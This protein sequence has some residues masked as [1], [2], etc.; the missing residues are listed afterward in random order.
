MNKFK[1]ILYSILILFLFFEVLVVFPRHLKN[2]NED[3][4]DNDLYEE[5]LHKSDIAAQKM[6]GVHLVESKGGVKVWELMA[7]KAEG[8]EATGNWDL[9]NVKLVLYNENRVSFIILGLEGTIENKTKNIQIRGG[10]RMQSSNGYRFTTNAVEYISSE[11]ELRSRSNISMIGPVTTSLEDK[12]AKEPVTDMQVTAQSMVVHI[13]ENR[14][15]LSNSVKTRR[16]FKDQKY[17]NVLS[18]KSEFSSLERLARFEGNVAIEFH[19][20]KSVSMDCPFAEFKYKAGTN[21]LESIHLNC[22][23]RFKDESQFAT[24][25]NIQIDVDQ[26]KFTLKGSPKLFQDEDELFGEEIVFLDGGKKVKVERVRA[27]MDELKKSSGESL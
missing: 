12:S 3:L 16:K 18:D 8:Y 13:H 23:V 14:M 7:A 20:S 22:G 17:F 11:S 4:S 15:I 25:D 1:S 19:E 26:N 6:E 10:A 21:E 24:A 27:K 9:R 5:N 2:T